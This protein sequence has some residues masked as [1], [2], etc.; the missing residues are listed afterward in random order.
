[1][2]QTDLLLLNE[3]L[4]MD[5]NIGITKKNRLEMAKILNHLLASEYVL[6][7]KTWK[8]HWN[9]EG[10][11][12]HALHL[13]FDSQVEQLE[14]IIDRVAERVRA[15]DIKAEATLTEFL[16]ETFL[17]EQ[18]GKNPNDLAMIKLLLEDHEE[19]IRKMH[20]DCEYSMDLEDIGT[21]NMLADLIEEHEKMAWMLR[22]FLQ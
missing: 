1:M 2:D 15:L 20:K 7:T 10:K 21:N 18:P 4:S 13:F 11:H 22:A 8:F 16:K 19:I 6:Y 5:I 12:F 17:K 9:V 14:K 3:E